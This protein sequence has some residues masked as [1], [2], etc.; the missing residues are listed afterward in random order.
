MIMWHLDSALAFVKELEPSLIQAGYH[1]GLLGSV[2]FNGASGKDLD[3]LIYP[4]NKNNAQSFDAIW[5][6]IKILKRPENSNTCSQTQIRD[7]KIVTWMLL[8]DG[9]RVDFF[10]MS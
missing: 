10:F 8:A 5:T 1:C 2:I 9:R 7:N 6:L 3:V 4:H